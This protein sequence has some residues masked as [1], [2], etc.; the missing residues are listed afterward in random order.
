MHQLIYFEFVIR[1]VDNSIYLEALFSQDIK[2][3]VFCFSH[4]SV[5]DVDYLS[6]CV[7]FVLDLM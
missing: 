4:G 5:L 6:A 1:T 2:K 3:Y 7:S